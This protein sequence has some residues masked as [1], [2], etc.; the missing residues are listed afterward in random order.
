MISAPVGTC[1]INLLRW[2]AQRK[3]KIYI[4]IICIYINIYIYYISYI[5]ILIYVFIEIQS[6]SKY[7]QGEFLNNIS[8]PWELKIDLSE[9]MAPKTN[10]FS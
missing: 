10:K 7:P 1:W 3:V 8:S 6:V 5:I 2:N 4:Y 9:N